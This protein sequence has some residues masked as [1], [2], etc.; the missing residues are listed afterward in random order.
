MAGLPRGKN[1]AG[2]PRCEGS[3]PPAPC[4]GE[5]GLAAG[6]SWGLLRHHWGWRK[7]G[8]GVRGK[9]GKKGKKKGKKGKKREKGERNLQAGS[10][11][12]ELGSAVQGKSW[13]RTKGGEEGKER[14]EGPLIAGEEAAGARRGGGGAGEKPHLKESQARGRKDR[15]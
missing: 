11:R 15:R 4:Q 14:G 7:A 8:A 3:G 10:W 2:R 1:I 5:P 12:G 13:Q 9:K 6:P